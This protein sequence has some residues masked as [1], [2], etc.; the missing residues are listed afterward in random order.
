M[1]VFSDITHESLT[2]PTESIADHMYR[3]SMLAIFAPPSLSSRL[4]IVKVTKMC[5]FHDEYSLFHY[6]E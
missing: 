3:M 5:L 2:F 4:D 1:Y 6:V